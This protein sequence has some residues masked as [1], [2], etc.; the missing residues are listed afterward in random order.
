MVSEFQSVSRIIGWDHAFVKFLTGADS[1]DFGF[2]GRIDCRCD[3]QDGR[4]WNF[5]DEDLAPFHA[6]ECLDDEINCFL[7]CDDK[8]SHFWIGDWQHTRLSLFL[9]EWDDRS[10]AAPDVA[11]AYN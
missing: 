3:I 1:D 4:T 6:C 8:P 10:I 9:K 7:E 11:I 2:A 5:G